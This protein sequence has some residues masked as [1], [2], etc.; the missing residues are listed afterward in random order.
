MN[1]GKWNKIMI[2]LIIFFYLKVI[3]ELNLEE[4]R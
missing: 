1:I 3:I 2:F 4:G